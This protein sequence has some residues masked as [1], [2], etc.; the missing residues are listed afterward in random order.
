MSSPLERAQAFL[1][2]EL[3]CVG[4]TLLKGSHRIQE[5]Y[6]SAD[7]GMVIAASTVSICVLMT[8]AIL[9]QGCSDTIFLK[10]LKLCGNGSKEQRKKDEKELD[11]AEAEIFGDKTRERG[12]SSADIGIQALMRSNIP[13]V[14]WFLLVLIVLA[15]AYHAASVH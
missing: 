4:N 7:A 8:L 10:G 11:E 3:T 9:S 14:T 1:V 12:V 2:K 6:G 13:K 5:F 15:S